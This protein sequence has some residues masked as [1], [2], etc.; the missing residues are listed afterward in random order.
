[1]SCAIRRLC[2]AVLAAAIV[3]TGPGAAQVEPPPLP[4]RS[5][6]ARVVAHADRGE[7]EVIIG[8]V[9]L[10]AKGPHLR[11]PIQLVTLP[12]AGWLHGFDW[13]MRD[14]A[15]RELPER[16]LHHVNLIDP[17]NRELFAPVSRRVVAAGRETSRERIPRLL[18]YP[19]EEGTRFLVSAM[20]ANPTDR[21]VAEA[22]LHVRLFYSTED[23]GFFNPRPV[24]PFYLDVMGLVTE[25][26]DFP[27]PPGRTTMSWEAS[28]AIDARILGIGGHV[29][30]YATRLRLVDVTSGKV[31]WEVEPERDERGRVSDVRSSRWWWRGGV[32]IHKDHVYRIEVEYENP[33]DRPAPD[34]GMGA[35]GGIVLASSKAEWPELDRRSRAYARDLQY[36]LEKPHRTDG[37]DH[38]HGGHDQD[39]DRHDHEHGIQDH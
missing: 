25:E 26:K 33:T 13:E 15:G 11:I 8:P 6:L 10:P 28:P 1:M 27:V 23:D 32:R 7:M 21:D 39:H 5:D 3:H 12:A 20:F 18:G 14:A 24:Y 34:G 36:T 2:Y 16:L 31:I 4:E 9:S 30:D 37:H 38:G 35:I 19:L 17:D 22:Y 29:H